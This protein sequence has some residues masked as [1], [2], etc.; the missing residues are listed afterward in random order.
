MQK[1]ISYKNNSKKGIGLGKI[2]GFVVVSGIIAVLGLFFWYNQQITRP[3]SDNS[4]EVYI[5]IEQGENRVQIANKLQELGIIKD[6]NIFLWYT[7]I[8]GEGSGIKSGSHK[9]KKDV[10]IKELVTALE[11]APDETTV[12]A[13]IPEGLR[14]DEIANIIE[15]A[16]EGEEDSKFNKGEFLVISENPHTATLNPQ[17]MQFINANIPV[18]KPIEG[19]LYPDTYN[20]FVNSTTEDVVNTLVGTFMG[21]VGSQEELLNNSQFSLYEVVTIASMLER[22][23][24]NAEEAKMIADVIIKRLNDGF[25]LGIDAT[26]LYEQKNWKATLDNS[27]FESNSPY[28]TRKHLGLPPTPISNPNIITID[29]AINPVS[30]EYYYYLHDSNNQIHYGRDNAEHEANKRKYLY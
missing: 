16:F 18:G 25:F 2:F 14:Y 28:N 26:T 27:D 8:S 3:L 22:E 1:H 10:N 19:F 20:F 13:T 23:A 15:K 29:A 7:K 11:Q 17:V 5:N 24:Y 4:E 30:N 9:F 12:W 21:K 6:T